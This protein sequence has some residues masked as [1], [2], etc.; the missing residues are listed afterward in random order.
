MTV[1]AV[2][3]SDSLLID[4]WPPPNP[5]ELWSQRECSISVFK[6]LILSFEG[7]VTDICLLNRTM[8]TG[9]LDSLTLNSKHLLVRW[10]IW[11]LDFKYW[12]FQTAQTRPIIPKCQSYYLTNRCF[13]VKLKLDMRTW[14]QSL[15]RLVSLYETWPGP[16]TWLTEDLALTWWYSVNCLNTRLE[17]SDLSCDFRLPSLSQ[18]CGVIL[19]VSDWLEMDSEVGILQ[20]RICRQTLSR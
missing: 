1:V 16:E 14:Q 19:D 6:Y 10:L 8:L 17:Q 18:I 13:R 12:H 5:F 9:W 11:S 4:P 3:Q 20:T 7:L 15:L 2:L